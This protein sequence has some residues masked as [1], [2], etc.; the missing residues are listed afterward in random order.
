MTAPE[1]G[2]IEVGV[3]LDVSRESAAVLLSALMVLK[4]VLHS[5][6]EKVAEALHCDDARQALLAAV[7][8][9]QHANIFDDSQYVVI[10]NSLGKTLLSTALLIEAVDAAPVEPEETTPLQQKSTATN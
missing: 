10:A 2:G 3:Q 4:A 8:I 7:L 9:L 5:S 1:Q 6:P